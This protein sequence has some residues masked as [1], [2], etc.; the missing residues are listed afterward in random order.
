MHYYCYLGLQWKEKRNLEE[1]AEIV[2]NIELGKDTVH[3]EVSGR[4]YRKD[5][6]KNVVVD[7]RFES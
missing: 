5:C 1:A 6:S 2:E 3:A 4:N 7:D